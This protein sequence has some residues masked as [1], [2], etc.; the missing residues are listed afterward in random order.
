MIEKGPISQQILLIILLRYLS[1]DGTAQALRQA[2]FQ[3]GTFAIGKLFTK[4]DVNQRK[5]LSFENFMELCL[6]LTNL[7]SLF[8]RFDTER[9]GKITLDLDTF[10]DIFSVL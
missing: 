2:Q 6:A 4:Y 1:M 9:V 8:Y 5:K 10:T 3:V 7:K